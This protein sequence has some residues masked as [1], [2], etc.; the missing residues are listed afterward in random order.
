ME[1]LTEKLPDGRVVLRHHKHYSEVYSPKHGHFI[2]GEAIDRLA[3]YETLEKQGMLLKLPCAVGTQI[4]VIE[5]HLGGG[6]VP[7]WK[8]I[9]DKYFFH[10]DMLVDRNFMTGNTIFGK[11]AFLTREEAEAAL[12]K[13]Q[14]G[15]K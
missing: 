8:E 13:I 4:Y 9:S 10:P 7:D 11:N 5:T 6:R 12:K 15:V 1:R 2:E 14:E 3:E